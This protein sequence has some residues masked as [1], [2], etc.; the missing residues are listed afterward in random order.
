VLGSFFSK[1]NL[2]LIHDIFSSYELFEENIEFLSGCLINN[3]TNTPNCCVDQSI[4][5]FLIDVSGDIDLLLISKLG[6]KLIHVAVDQSD[7]MANEE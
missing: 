6:L 1:V 4:C 7:H 3:T 5:E 2:I